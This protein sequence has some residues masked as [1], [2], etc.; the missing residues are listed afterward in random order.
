MAQ[1]SMVQEEARGYLL[2]LLCNG[3]LKVNDHSPFTIAVLRL[4]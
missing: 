3:K 4:T 2:Q 1:E